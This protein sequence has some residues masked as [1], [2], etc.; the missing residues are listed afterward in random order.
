MVG[1]AELGVLIFP[2]SPATGDGACAD[3]A[4]ME[5]VRARLAPLAASATGSSTRVGRAMIL[6]EPPSL[7]AQEMTAKGN[8]NT[9]KVLTRRAGLLARLYDESDPAVIRP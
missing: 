8:L 6:T 3:P 5:E 2:A 7:E 1:R 9:R 4:R